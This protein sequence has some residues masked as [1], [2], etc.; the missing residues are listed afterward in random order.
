MDYTQS[1][2]FVTD[3]GTGNR[4]HKQDQAIPT[5]ISD[6]DMNQVIWSLMEV[7][8]VVS[9]A[10]TQFDPTV[11]A[12]YTKVRDAIQKLMQR[13]TPNI[14]VAAGTADAI[15]ATF[16]PVID[17]VTAGMRLMVRASGANT[18]TTPTFTPNA[19]TIAP[20][21]IVKGADQPLAV[22]DIPAAG[23]W[24]ELVADL[25]TEK[26]VL[27]NPFGSD[28]LGLF[29]GSNQDLSAN[30]YQKLPGGLILQWGK[31]L[32]SSSS[33]DYR[34]FPIPFPNACFGC[35]IQIDVATPSG[36]SQDIGTVV[37]VVDLDKFVFSVAGTFSGSP[38]SAS[39][40]F[41]AIGK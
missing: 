29:D 20:W 35:F 3:V 39:V 6:E 27:V 41:W 36:F 33:T 4:M 37:S 5:L 10:G 40:Y 9:I 1:D 17:S 22:G 13:Q 15:S 34:Y 30:G 12:S 21:E 7:L 38:D 2:S 26:W 14:G 8:K 23:F 18:S 32:E 28:V 19:G 16:A 24:M 25:V 31:V 11:P